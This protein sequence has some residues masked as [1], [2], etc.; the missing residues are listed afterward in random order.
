MDF[1]SLPKYRGLRD[2]FPPQK[3]RGM[4]RKWSDPEPFAVLVTIALVIVMLILPWGLLLVAWM[5]FFAG[6]GALP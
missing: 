1:R 5:F 2:S 6:V 4:E 3:E